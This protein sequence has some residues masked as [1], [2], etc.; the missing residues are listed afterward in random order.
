MV[1]VLVFIPAVSA[2]VICEVDCIAQA[3]AKGQGQ[4]TADGHA[5]GTDSHGPGSHDHLKDAG[6]CHLAA[7][8]FF[9]VSNV[10]TTAIGPLEDQWQSDALAA[11]A[12]V[13]W[14][15]PRPRPKLIVS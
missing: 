8:P 1:L 11:Y 7:T 6:P 15:P 3:L 2:M 13:I 10:S 12:S 14:P 4:G 9:A 5:V